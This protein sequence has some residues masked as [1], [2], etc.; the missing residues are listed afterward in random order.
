M[1]QLKVS[2][3]DD[4]RAKLEASSVAS[5]KSLGEDIRDRLERTFAEDLIDPKTRDLTDD[6]QGLAGELAAQSHTW[7]A[8]PKAFEA[9]TEAVKTWLEFQRPRRKGVGVS[10]MIDA[11]IDDPQT[12]GRTIARTLWRVKQAAEDGLKEMRKLHQDEGRS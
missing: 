3:D 6:I 11:S 10:D 12:L 2:L 5:G 9:F 8:H 1:K 4:L 7:H